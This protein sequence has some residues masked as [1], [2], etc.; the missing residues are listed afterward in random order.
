MEVDAAVTMEKSA[1]P[2]PVLARVALWRRALS[3]MPSTPAG[4]FTDAQKTF[5]STRRHGRRG[6]AGRRYPS[7]RIRV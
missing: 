4:G 1:A 5:E 6:G 3:K 7:A 2:K